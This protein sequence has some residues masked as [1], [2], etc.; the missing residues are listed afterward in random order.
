MPRIGA[1]ENEM[2]GVQKMVWYM[3][4]MDRYRPKTGILFFSNYG[5]SDDNEEPRVDYWNSVTVNQEDWTFVNYVVKSS[6]KPKY[7]KQLN[8]VFGQIT[9]KLLLMP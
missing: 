5:N 6:R 3:V 1:M 4:Q 8:S 9:S 7:V 2:E